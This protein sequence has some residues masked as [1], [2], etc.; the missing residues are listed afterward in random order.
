MNEPTVTICERLRRLR[1]DLF[2]ERGKSKMARELG[3]R[4]STYDRYER[5]RVP[6]A[7]LLVKIAEV[8]NVTLEWLVT[9]EGPRRP[10]QLL[11]RDSHELARQFE[12]AITIDP[13][14]RP[15]AR[16]F[17]SWLEDRRMRPD[18]T[19]PT[20]EP[21]GSIASTSSTG[22][23]T[24]QPP[25]GGS[26][27]EPSSRSDSGDAAAGDSDDS[28]ARQSGGHL[29]PLSAPQST[30]QGASRSTPAETLDASQLIPIIGRTSAG[31]AR[32]WRDLTITS[33]R[34]LDQAIGRLLDRAANPAQL[35]PRPI[36][37][38]ASTHSASAAQ[39]LQIVD[40]DAGPLELLSVPELKGRFPRAVAWQI[41]GDSMEP[42]Y[43]HGDIVV[44]S[45]DEPAVEGQPCVVRQV[46]Q[47]GM[48]CKVFHRDGDEIVLIPI[49]PRVEVQRV[50]RQSV[51]SAH[52]VLFV[53]R[54]L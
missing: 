32:Y 19:P 17:L 8:A 23:V 21:P 24:S 46:G 30:S 35:I 15:V 31:V 43:F 11:D 26:P 52:R 41:D 7:D 51:Q 36:E 5:D 10:P 22:T 20:F 18:S 12:E 50:P 27:R 9:G 1:T 3:I 16:A 38:E 42:R 25:I 6:P 37:A 13:S 40:R 39:L 54:G 33:T 14:L 49:N 45:S 4:P 44:T 28:E 47:V 48:S 53:V 29:S 34:E 2:G